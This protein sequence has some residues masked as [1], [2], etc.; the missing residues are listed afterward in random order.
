MNNM[1]NGY[2][3]GNHTVTTIVLLH[4]PTQQTDGHLFSCY[5]M[6]Y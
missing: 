2:C 6:N 4:I 3:K 5:F 1:E